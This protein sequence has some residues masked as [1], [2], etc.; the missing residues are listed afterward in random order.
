MKCTDNWEGRQVNDCY[1]NWLKKTK[2]LKNYEV[3]SAGRFGNKGIR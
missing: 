2:I 1:L 3:L